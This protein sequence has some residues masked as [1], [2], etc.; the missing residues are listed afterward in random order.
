MLTSCPP[1]LADITTANSVA[2]GIDCGMAVLR[3]GRVL[4][5]GYAEGSRIGL[6]TNDPDEK[7]ETPRALKKDVNGKTLTWAECGGRFS[8]VALPAETS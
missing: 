8:V 5:W 1:S 6:G 3:D 4:A 7:I 2:A